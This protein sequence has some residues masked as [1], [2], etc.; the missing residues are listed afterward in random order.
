MSSS[1]SYELLKPDTGFVREHNVFGNLV[2][3]FQVNGKKEGK[4][5]EYEMNGSVSIFNYVNDM[6]EVLQIAL[7]KEKV[8]HN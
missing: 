5:I 3:Y 1:M 6:R 4:C 7:L 8:K 2:E